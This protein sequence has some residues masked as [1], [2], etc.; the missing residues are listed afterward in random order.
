AGT[1]G[2]QHVV[3]VGDASPVGSSFRTV[4][5]ASM[6]DS[7]TFAFRGDLAGTGTAGVF[8]ID[9]SGV[10]PVAQSVV[11]EGDTVGGPEITVR[12]LPSS[13]TPA[14]NAGGMVA[15]RATLSGG[16]GGSAIFV[17]PPGAPLQRIVTAKDATAVGSLVRLRDPVIADDGSLVIPTSVTGKG[18]L[19]VVARE[20][21]LSPL[22]QVGEATDIDN[23]DERF[24]FGQPSVRDVA[25]DAVFIGSREGI[26]VASRD[27]S[28]EMLAFVGGRAPES[29]GGTFA[30]FDPPA[31]DAPGIV[32]FGAEIKGSK[33][34][35]AIVASGPGGG[36]RMAAKSSE[37]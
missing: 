30:G 19:L 7:A 13:L 26:F 35:R 25:E 34:A 20:G 31:G 9:A 29:L 3:L 24:R 14:V 21:A 18:S 23:G 37:R 28:L 17:A 10:A 5:G 2:V 4:T 36:L 12:T 15:F 8:R 32:A 27:G 33:V 6:N 11:L 16:A 22:A 1:S